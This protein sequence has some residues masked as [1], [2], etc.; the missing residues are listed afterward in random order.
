MQ[1]GQDSRRELLVW[2]YIRDIGKIYKSMTIPIEINDIIYLY[3]RIYAKWSKEYSNE[4]LSIDEESLKFDTKYV[5][6]AFG[7]NEIKEGVFRWKLK[8]MTNTMDYKKYNAYPYVGIIE[9]NTGNF[10]GFRSRGSWQRVGCQLCANGGLWGAYGNSTSTS[11]QCKWNKQGDIL[12]IILDLNERTLRFGV[13]G[14]DCDTGFD[15]IKQTS[16]RLALTA[17]NAAGTE[18]VFV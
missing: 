12:E 17:G 14:S 1:K 13:N 16:Y 15:D 5:S 2:G 4:D 9:S 6:T 3:Q 10:E 8:M 18:F 7:D 11:S